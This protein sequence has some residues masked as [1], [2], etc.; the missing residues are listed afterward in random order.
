MSNTNNQYPEEVHISRKQNN[1]TNWSNGTVV[2]NISPDYD[3]NVQMA[4]VH[5]SDGSVTQYTFSGEHSDIT[6]I[7]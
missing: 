5:K 3:P 6:K 4:Y 1:I 7:R 2:H